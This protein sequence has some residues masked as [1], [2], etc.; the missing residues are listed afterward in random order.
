MKVLHIIAPIS[1]GGGESLLY[2]LLKE[3]NDNCI[4]E[5]ALI[6]NSPLFIE[7]LEEI[8]I[9][10]YVLRDKE[11][12]QAMP[13]KEVFLDSFKNLLLFKDIIKLVNKNNFTHIHAHGYPASL[14]IY[15]VKLFKKDIKTIYTHHFYREIPSSSIE[16]NIFRAIYNKFDILTGVSQTVSNSLK[17]AF[18]LNKDVKTVYNCISNDF[19]VDSKQLET[20][21]FE[22]IRLSKKIKFIQIARF[23]PFKNHMYIVEAVN[24]LERSHLENILIIFAGTG[25][26]LE[27]IK[28]LVKKYDLNKY[29]IFLGMV[30]YKYIPSLIEICD[31]GLFPSDLEGFGIGAVECMAKGLP[32]LAQDNLLMREIVKENGVLIEKEKFCL[33]FLEIL[34]KFF[35]RDKIVND[36]KKFT[37]HNIKREYLSLYKEIE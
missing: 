6:Y 37:P 29:F 18:C 35:L 20:N 32:V 34:T 26:E 9:K 8:N 7:K 16:K 14:I 25:P 10:Y 23:S 15:F 30:E 22:N 31:F 13:R 12:G 4:E 1:F 21:N 27:K 17:K 5:I 11:I 24:K 33:G 28:Q 36:T 2:N 19:F 3:K